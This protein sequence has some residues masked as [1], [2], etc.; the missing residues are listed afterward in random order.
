M[1]SE[2]DGVEGLV[3]QRR[4]HVTAAIVTGI[5]TLYAVALPLLAFVVG[6]RRVWSYR[7]ADSLWVVALAGLAVVSIVHRTFDPNIAGVLAAWWMCKTGGALAARPPA[8][9]HAIRWGLL[10]GWT[11]LLLLSIIQVTVFQFER[12]PGPSWM[13]HPNLLAHAWIA[14]TALAAVL[15][16]TRLLGSGVWLAAP[17]GLIVTGSRSGA[18]AAVVLLLALI[19][20]VRTTRRVLVTALVAACAVGALIVLNADAGWVQRILGTPQERHSS[21]TNI[22]GASEDLDARG[23]WAPLEVAVSPVG[24]LAMPPPRA[25]RIERTGDAGWARPQQ[26]IVLPPNE[27]FTLSGEFLP[28]SADATPGYL[29]WGRS[30][31]EVHELRAL[32]DPDGVTVS[33]LGRLLVVDSGSDLLDGGWSRLW[34][35]FMATGAAPVVLAVGP[36]PNL[37]T[38]A[39]GDTALVRA[40]QLS[41]GDVLTDYV[42]THAQQVSPHVVARFEAL[43]RLEY[44]RVAI[45]SIT[46]RPIFGW[47]PRSFPLIVSLDEHALG[48]APHP[49]N[50]VLASAVEGGVF[51]LL[52]L[53][54]LVWA[55][56]AR[57]GPV[58]RA[59]VVALLAANLV[60][61]TY[62]STFV[63]FP[64]AMLV[65]AESARR[66]DTFLATRTTP[67][68]QAPRTP[69][70]P[71]TTDHGGH[72]RG[73]SG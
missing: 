16:P 24:S 40:L 59:V 51:G 6:V 9:T 31:D 29:A 37:T 21:P 55:L 45:E 19:P 48:W 34:V 71:G 54:G 8:T 42:A 22:L 68:R 32:V 20:F 2:N 70:R 17:L 5:C 25:W 69:T 65:G 27:A 30:A 60:D 36:S 3:P 15:A 53:I 64:L 62:L 14:L 47:G 43:A 13:G 7:T 50:Q 56:L 63:L 66:Q 1:S 61:T 44:W 12:A 67:G 72:T 35:S 41:R 49:H 18:V 4:V 46:T 33:T 58:G 26:S 52:S 39:I 38:P 57:A 73:V 10:G 11:L 23:Y 28:G